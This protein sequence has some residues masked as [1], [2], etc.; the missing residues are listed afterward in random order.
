MMSIGTS[1]FSQPYWQLILLAIIDVPF[2]G[3]CIAGV[4]M[5]CQKVEMTALANLKEFI[6]PAST[7]G[8]LSMGDVTSIKHALLLIQS[9]T[10]TRPTE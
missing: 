3:N 9:D 10:Q 1:K 5:C 7:R 2:Q 8:R 6:K 4:H